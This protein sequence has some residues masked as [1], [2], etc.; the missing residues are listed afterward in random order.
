MLISLSRFLQSPSLYRAPASPGSL[1]HASYLMRYRYCPA[2]TYFKPQSLCSHIRLLH[3]DSKFLIYI[4][5]TYGR[6]SQRFDCRFSISSREDGRAGGCLIKLEIFSFTDKKK[7]YMPPPHSYAW[8]LL[9]AWFYEN[10]G[11]RAYL[12]YSSRK[13]RALVKN[14]YFSSSRAFISFDINFV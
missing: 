9:Y 3:C 8:F 13:A 5:F 7:R 14:T 10:Y 1:G 2:L 11:S 12:L 6:R 4:I